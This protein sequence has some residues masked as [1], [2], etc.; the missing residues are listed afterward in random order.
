MLSIGCTPP[1]SEPLGYTWPRSST[2]SMSKSVVMPF[3]GWFHPSVM[4]ASPPLWIERLSPLDPP[5]G[6]KS[7]QLT[8]GNGTVANC[9][10]Q[11]VGRYDIASY[12]VTFFPP[13]MRFSLPAAE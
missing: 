12:E 3:I 1:G 2:T 11:E 6:A 4:N 13:R 9:E 8:G 5:P 10:G 7:W